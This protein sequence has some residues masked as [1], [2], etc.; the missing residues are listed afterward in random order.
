MKKIS[1]VLLIICFVILGYFLWPRS[2]HD[3]FEPSDRAGVVL[4]YSCK[5]QHIFKS[6]FGRF[7]ESFE[8]LE[9]VPDTQL[10]R[11]EI[12]MICDS[13]FIITAF[14]TQL[15][16]SDNPDNRNVR[17][18]IDSKNCDLSNLRRFEN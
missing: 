17:W 2:I 18:Q 4:I 6:Q 14:P 12:E 7:T 10:Y 13:F 5:K 1:F 11:Y 16:N 3:S 8:E 9:F 15:P